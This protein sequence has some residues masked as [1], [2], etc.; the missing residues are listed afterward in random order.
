M[1]EFLMHELL[2]I[3]AS[4]GVGYVVWR[5]Y[6]KLLYAMS[7]AIIGGVLIDLDHLFDY[8]TVFGFSWNLEY[9]IKG[10]NFLKNDKI[11]VLFHGY[12]YV[13]ALLILFAFLSPAYK[14]LR[15][16]LLAFILAFFFHLIIDTVTNDITL[17]AYFIGERMRNNFQI[18]K[19][20]SP[21]GYK[22]HLE[23][24]KNLNL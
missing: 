14:K 3:T 22:E 23:R 10:Y 15:I 7:A 12:E 4:L 9:F 6:G 21:E 17:K 16:A 19:L 1:I 11:Y 2:H 20:I 18:E 5:R 8:Y 24:K 13:I